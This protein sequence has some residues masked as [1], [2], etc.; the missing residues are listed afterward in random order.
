MSGLVGVILSGIIYT[1][2]SQTVGVTETKVVS[3]SPDNAETRPQSSSVDDTLTAHFQKEN[4]EES[5][6]Y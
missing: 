4:A 3:V 5:E 2:N 6:R 1:H